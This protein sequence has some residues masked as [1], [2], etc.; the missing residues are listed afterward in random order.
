[1]EPMISGRSRLGIAS[2]LLNQ[3]EHDLQVYGENR[4]LSNFKQNAFDYLSIR[5]EQLSLT[6]TVI[7]RELLRT[8]Y[9][10]LDA[11]HRAKYDRFILEHSH[12]SVHAKLNIALSLRLDPNQA[13]KHWHKHL[14]LSKTGMKVR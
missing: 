14:N 1:M 6:L 4:L 10:W 9:K 2:S 8:I 11:S 12:L 13:A 3:L 7:K 5:L